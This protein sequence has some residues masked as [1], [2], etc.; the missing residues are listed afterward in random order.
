MSAPLRVAVI[1]DHF[2]RPDFF[3][4]ALA[5]AGEGAFRVRSLELNWPNTPM[6]HGYGD[7]TMDGLKEYLGDPAEIVDFIGDAQV[8]ITHLAPL[9]SAMLDRLPA[10]RLIG[11][12]RGGPV[13]INVAAARARG[14][15]VVNAPGRNASAVAEF[16]IGAILAE[17]RRM[18]RGHMALCQGDWRGD[19]YR[20]DITGRELSEMTVGLIGYGAIGSRLPPLLKPF[21][22]RILA[23]DPYVAMPAADGVE[24]THLDDLLRRSD[25]V[26]LHARVTEET[27]GF[28]AAEQFARMRDGAFFINTA[29]GPMVDYDALFAALASR[30]LGG[31]MLDT[32]AIEP[33]PRDWPLLGLDNVTLT[34]HIAGA[35]V[36]TIR[37]AAA[38]IAG[39]VARYVRGQA[40]YHAIS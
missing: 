13:N 35:S 15:Q 2:M 33:P 5:A 16:T 40:L 11:V 18:T 19:L 34:P 36:Y 23:C 8:C 30:K 32:F 14:I 38:M 37:N 20:A 25:V 6:V 21:G 17:T 22:C 12:S 3:E 28:L 7:D 4:A 24:Q 39:D 31:A 27:R 9:T 1:G 26:S 29:R 10:L